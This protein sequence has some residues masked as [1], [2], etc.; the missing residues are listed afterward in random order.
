M[1]PVIALVGRPNVGKSTLFNCL[2]KTRDALVADSP[3]LTRDRQYGLGQVGARPYI[4][5]DTG[6]LTHPEQSATIRSNNDDEP[7]LAIDQLV[8]QQAL[9]AIV[10]ADLILLLVDS[11]AGLTGADQT[12]VNRLRRLAKPIYLIVNK[13]EH[14]DL[15]IATAEFYQLGIADVFA[16]SA[17]HRRGLDTLMDAVLADPA[18]NQNDTDSAPAL[19]ETESRTRIAIVGRPNVGKSTLINRLLGES[20]VLAFD[21]PGT[22]RDSIE[23]PFDK[24]EKL[25]T[26]IDT[27]GVRRRSR[28]NEMIEKFSVIKTLQAIEQA[29]VVILLLDARQGVS[30]QDAT[31]LGYILEQGRA[32]VVAINKWDRLSE[33]VRAHTRRELN[34]RLAFID[35][36]EFHFISAL[37]GSGV[38][39][40]IAAVDRA[41]AAAVRKL[42][43]PL[44][45]QVLEH[46]LHT[47]QPPL[48]HGHS[49]RLRYAH[50]GGQAP[51]VIVIHGTRTQQIP[52]TYRRY[53]ANTFRKQLKLHG[54]PIRIVFKNTANPYQSQKTNPK[55]PSMAQRRRLR[56][57]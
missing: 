50:Q 16:I 42:P 3:G 49:I 9:Q 4:V 37:H 52:E 24:Q 25:Y 45:N 13:T 18:L 11:R 12:I 28:V 35:F 32:L 55:R 8:T 27:A 38:T 46:A 29:H 20:R 7:S 30:E 2:T 51:P 22:T 44:L 5:V 26:L 19:D 17:S 54:T 21:R 57:S 1:L 10:E 15:S 43:T 34:R 23:I 48:V 33:D 40:L 39:D 47:H 14:L 53:L 31:L 56:K 6:G 36:A 41:Y